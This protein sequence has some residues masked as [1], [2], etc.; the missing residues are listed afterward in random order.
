MKIIIENL[1]VLK[2]A[3][4]ELGD[5]TLICG[6]NNTGKT[7]ATYALFGFLRN[8]QRFVSAEV[9]DQKIRELFKD[10][11]TQI[12]IARHVK[13]AKNILAEGCQRYTQELP[14]IFASNPKHFEETQFQV[15]LNLDLESILSSHVER[16]IR[17][18]KSELLSLSKPKGESHLAVSLLADAEKIELP[19]M[20]IKDIVSDII[21]EIIFDQ[22][23]PNPFIVSAE[24]T[25]AAIFS[26]ELDFA[27]NRLLK[28]MARADKDID[29]GELLS[30]SYNDY[31]SPVQANVDFTRRVADITNE[32]SFIVE[33][34]AQILDEFSEIIGGKYIS[35]SNDSIYFKPSGK[36]RS[37]KMGESSSAVRSM[38]DIGSYLRYIAKP[39]DLLMVDEP[40]LSLHPEN[41]RRVARLFARLI[42]LEIRVFITT[43]SDYIIKEL[44]TLIMLNQDKPHLKRIAEKWGYQS[45]EFV[46]AEKVKVYV[47]EKALIKTKSSNK[48]RSR[49]QTLKEAEVSHEQ[50][51]DARSFDETIDEMNEI[52]EAIVWGDGE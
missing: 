23:L 6:H 34:H 9:S 48:K 44:N 30:K 24:R 25:G 14:E 38:L 20:M 19:T 35:G 5:L 3:A 41:Q 10:G 42:N 7:Y 33:E 46:E 51:I 29:L 50:G 37:L 2:K 36:D 16:K 49:H 1:G 22:Y 11:A 15:Q 39:D 26:K 21:S 45:E 52:Q 43:H 4:F 47:A 17:S 18:R 27:R 28:E 32:D 40:E 31:A 8:W 12:D 13:N